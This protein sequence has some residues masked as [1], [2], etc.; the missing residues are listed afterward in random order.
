MVEE[1]LHEKIARYGNIVEEYKQ[2]PDSDGILFTA[3]TGNMIAYERM[4]ETNREDA[5]FKDP[6]AQ[7]LVG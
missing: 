6:Y 7:Y 5:L 1:T 4:L 3:A 2:T